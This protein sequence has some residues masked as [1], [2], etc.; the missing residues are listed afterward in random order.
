MAGYDRG[1]SLSLALPHRGARLVANA[2]VD[3]AA[4]GAEV[5][6]DGSRL[7]NAAADDVLGLAADQ[8]VKDAAIAAIKRFG[9]EAPRSSTLVAQLEARAATRLKADAAALVDSVASVLRSLEGAEASAIV[10]VRLAARFAMSAPTFSSPEHLET[11]L[12]A[13]TGAPRFVVLE[14]VHPFEGDLSPLPR[15]VSLAQRNHVPVVVIDAWGPGVL[16]ATGTGVI[17]HFEL[18][19]QADLVVSV[20][21][22]QLACVSGVRAVVE[23]FVPALPSRLGTA[24]VAATLKRLELIETETHR[25]ARALDL[26]QVIHEALRVRSF[27]TGPSVTP[28]IPIWLGDEGLADVW[29]RQLAE[30]GLFARALL[31]GPRSRLVLSVSAVASDGQRDQIISA[32]ERLEKQLGSPPPLPADLPRAVTVA[33][34]GSYAVATPAHPRWR[35]AIDVA[36]SPEPRGDGRQLSERVL[37][38]VEALTWRLVSGQSGQLRR[39]PGVTAL[40]A[41]IDRARR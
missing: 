5:E 3:A 41:L 24:T 36:D 28:L 38:S 27:D 32:L 29:L 35:P 25:R 23:A 11:L 34:P 31:D 33:R 1:M 26:A 19:G 10:D 12:A 18:F 17:E 37:H 40:R 7:L 8:R 9:V 14:G 22:P 21:G 13:P 16:G 15:L 39:M 2:R 20:L 6:T 4:N 30:L